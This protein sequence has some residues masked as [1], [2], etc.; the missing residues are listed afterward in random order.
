LAPPTT[1][2]TVIQLPSIT[3]EQNPIGTAYT[4]S[5]LTA[6]PTFPASIDTYAVFT[7]PTANPQDVTYWIA[8]RAG[9]GTFRILDRNF[10]QINSVN[11]GAN[12]TAAAMSPMGDRFLILTSLL[13]IFNA[14]T[15]AEIQLPFIDV[16]PSPN[17]VAI[18]QNG[19]RAFVMSAF[20]QR[21]TAIDLQ[22]NTAVGSIPL[23]GISTGSIAVGPNGLLY[24]SAQNRVLEVDGSQTAFDSASIRRQFQVAGNIGKLQFT[25][26]GT[27]ALA[28]NQNTA[29]GPVVYLINLEAA[30]GGVATLNV[31]DPLLGSV[32][33]DKL[34]VISNSRAFAISS[35]TSSPSRHLYQLAS[36]DLPAAGQNLSAPTVSEAFFGSLATIPIVENLTFSK[37]FPSAR[38]LFIS[39][40]LTLLNSTVPSELY[41]IDATNNNLSSKVTLNFIPGFSQYVTPAQ[42]AVTAQPGLVSS[43]NGVQPAIPVN[44]RALPIGVRVTTSTGQPI[45]GLTVTFTANV[46]GVQFDNGGIATTNAD[47]LAFMGLTAPPNPGTFGVIASIA[48]TSLTAGFNLTA[49]TGGG[50]GGG[51]IGSTLEIVSGDGQIVREGESS[52]LPLTVIVRD[53]AGAP[54]PNVDV[55]WSITQGGGFFLEGEVASGE[56]ATTSV[57]T[58]KTDSRGIATNKFQAPFISS[59]FG[60]IAGQSVITVSTISNTLNM[61]TTTL[62]RITPEGSQ[63]SNPSQEFLAPTDSSQTIVGKVGE[64]LQ[65]AIKVRFSLPTPRLGFPMQN[66]GI[67]VSMEP[68]STTGPQVS[69]VPN[70]VPLSDAGGVVSCN[71][72]LSGR[73]GTGLLKVQLGGQIGEKYFNLVVNP[74]EPG[75]M[76]IVQGNGQSGRPNEVLP[77]QL[78]AVVR[79]AGGNPLPGATVRWE[80]ISGVATFV[81]TTTTSNTAGQVA[82]TV[83]LGSTPGPVQIRVTAVSGNQ[84][85][86]TF[87]AS[88]TQV[89]STF[90]K[91]SG[92]PQTAFTNAN[93]LNPLVVEVRDNNNQ[94]V[95]GANVEW[96]VVSGSATLTGTTP[97]A[98][99]ATGRAQ[100]TVRAGANAGPVQIRATVQNTNLTP[101][102]F[103]LTV[104]LPGPVVNV[105]SF[106]NTASGEFG[107]V[108]PGG[109]VTIVGDGLA[110]ALNGAITANLFNGPWPTRLN[111]VE[112][113]F[114]STLAPIYQV[115]NINGVQSVTVQ[116]PFDLAPGGNVA[117]TIRV[118]GGSTVVNSVPVVDYQPGIF[119]TVDASNRRYAV[120]IRPNGT[121]VTPEN[122]ARLGERIRI[123]VVCLGQVSPAVTAGQTGAGQ[124]VNAEIIVGFNNE[125]VR[126]VS[127]VYA[128][129]MVGVYEV[130]MEL[131][132]TGQTG[133]ERPIA[134]VVVRPNGQFVY[135]NG[136]VIPVAP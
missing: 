32:T 77:A 33:F 115:A 79:D 28:V 16:G 10:Q 50:G 64:T 80:I 61:Y 97:T 87:N 21:V 49:G 106:R 66:V 40:P 110:P 51:P 19:R 6:G 131:P 118:G 117:V 13:R 34:Y 120:A 99:S 72:R 20:G 5:P 98:T 129:N 52:F 85:N 127:A 122:P 103:N 44:G 53:T 18:S 56:S 60:D 26:D 93:Y 76:T 12:S 81:S 109:L 134:V 91:I 108:V 31:T 17:D 15:G 126:L 90:T 37:E 47:G 101:I 46:Q 43:L 25:P 38:Q 41:Q 75:Q 105:N 102:L 71:L 116:A 119:E 2:N 89:A 121:F 24:V 130:T 135:G 39:A 67:E 94:P 95:V 107:V 36:P 59:S 8:A 55:T 84:P 58:T 68:P 45:F 73:A 125:G 124:T 104:Q 74:G 133:N 57:R 4:V 35:S 3:G 1:A 29:A 111:N 100:M 27:R 128:Q 23:P 96:T 30:A 7:R 78:I 136:S 62:A 132:P 63:I 69:C 14:Q 123:Y 114:G 112:V 48:G 88:V 92:D 113:Q 65:E 82:A 22:T 83:R 9:S 86:A 42:P 11:L 54:L 70:P